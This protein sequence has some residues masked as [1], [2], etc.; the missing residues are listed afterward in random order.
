[1]PYNQRRSVYQAGLSI[2]DAL[3]F[4]SQDEI[5]ELVSD[6]SYHLDI[7]IDAECIGVILPPQFYLMPYGLFF[8]QKAVSATMWSAM[9]FFPAGL[10]FCITLVL[11]RCL[12][13][14]I[15]ARLD[16]WLFFLES[17]GLY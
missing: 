5:I 14:P 15:T 2:I 6:Y 7:I 12:H 10:Q 17:Q 1:M 11:V 13:Q 9:I 4:C 8:K 3:M 16:F